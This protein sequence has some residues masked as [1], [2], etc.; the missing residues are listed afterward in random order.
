MKKFRICARRDVSQSRMAEELE[1]SSQQGKIFFLF[2]TMSTPAL[3]PTWPP[4]K[5]VLHRLF[6]VK[7]MEHEGDINLQLMKMP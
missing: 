1:F 4:I 2:F 3:V 6:G 7:W 5:S